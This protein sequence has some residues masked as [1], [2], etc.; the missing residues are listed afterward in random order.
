MLVQAWDAQNG[1]PVWEDRVDNGGVFDAAYGIAVQGRQVFVQGF[2]GP[3]CLGTT[4][5]PSDCAILLRSYDAQT[6]ALLWDAKTGT[7]GVD[8]QITTQTLHAQGGTLF[9]AWG[10]NAPT[11]G[12]QGDWLVQA[13]DASTG[14][15][16]WEDLV[17]TGG[18]LRPLGAE[19]PLAVAM[20]GGRLF[21]AGRLVDATDNWNFVVRAYHAAGLDVSKAESR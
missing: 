5:P 12:P 2:G 11:T 16:R 6:G 19:I 3:K 1:A 7:V 18:G 10:V 20:F 9:G 14:R 21:V 4:S 13:F 17:D 15:L 8:D